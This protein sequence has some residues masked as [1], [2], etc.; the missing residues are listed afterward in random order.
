MVETARRTWELLGDG[1][2]ARWLLV[3]ALA[4]TA[5]G[6]EVAGALLVFA[7]LGAITSE[8]SGYVLP[9]V[10]DLRQR[11]PGLDDQQLLVVAGALVAGFFVLRA[12][13]LLI[14]TYV[15]Y[16]VAENAGARLASR[17]LEGYLAM[18]YTFHL[19]RNSAELVR[20]AYDITQQFAK[21]V[22]VPA[23][24]L[25]SHALLV[26]GLVSVLL[27]IDPVATALAVGALA[28]L[29]WGLLRVVH[30]KVKRLG[31]QAQAA[32]KRSLQTLNES[33]S[34]WRDITL[35][36]REASFADDF[37]RERRRLARSRYLR[38]TTSELP[39][40]VLETGLVL[41]ILGF[42]GLSVVLGDGALNA[43]P[44]LGLF[45]YTAVRLQP[46]LNEIMVSLNSLKF[47][48]AGVE[49]LSEDVRRFAAAG[50]PP[51]PPAARLAWSELRLEDVSVRYPAAQ[52]DAL[53]E[54]RLTLRAGEFVGIV[55][56]TGGG[57]STLADV[58]LGLV[59]PSTGV[60]T[61]DGVDLRQVTRTWQAGLGVVHQ[62]VFLADTTLR[63]NIALGVPEEEVDEI[64]LVEAVRLAQLEDFVASLPRGLDTVVGER[65]VN[66]SGGQR[67]RV[68]IARALY[69]R[70]SLLVF[71]E[72]TS[73]LDHATETEL[74]AALSALRGSRT[75]LAVAHRLSSLRDCDRLVV[76]ED[77]RI[78]AVGSFEDL[79]QSAD[80]PVSAR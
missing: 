31:K 65:G 72:G 37:A 10:G 30:P 64:A 7:L 36:G 5:T 9:G 26:A 46:S 60:V 20:N 67:Q 16:R 76:V 6:V 24:K 56:R 15:Q 74:M 3:L 51:P 14:Q 17:L 62:A 45:G 50:P 68:A 22:L 59:E 12:G 35:L 32:S 19:Q 44:I 1:T 42:L 11:L 47:A 43:L 23:V 38:S 41:F 61:I 63:R 57:K 75:I 13:V 77:G 66:V 25:V 18:P 27:L 40:V 28:P 53:S 8:A 55:G 69:R 58:V 49:L 2:R 21:E 52:R 71:D 80:L 48:A 29:T 33:L 70:P 73:A 54:L 78:V 79:E 39:R 4:L 34:G